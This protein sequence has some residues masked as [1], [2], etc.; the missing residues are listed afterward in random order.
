[1][2]TPTNA[3]NL[4]FFLARKATDELALL[5]NDGNE[6]TFDLN[7]RECTVALEISYDERTYS[8]FGYT[9]FGENA[10]ADCAALLA[11]DAS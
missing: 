2:N 5:V 6:V 7:G 9:F 3:A 1:M 10:V 11:R 8:A 4:F